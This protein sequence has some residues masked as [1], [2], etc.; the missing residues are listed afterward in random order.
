MRITVAVLR[1]GIKTKALRQRTQKKAAKVAGSERAW[2]SA[3]RIPVIRDSLERVASA[4][5][6]PEVA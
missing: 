5:F 6:R 4:R 3:E 2:T 1:L